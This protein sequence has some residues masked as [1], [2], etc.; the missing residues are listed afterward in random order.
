MSTLLNQQQP[1]VYM[2]AQEKTLGVVGQPSTWQQEQLAKGSFDS[3]LQN[4]QKRDL[5]YHTQL[6]QGQQAVSLP[7]SNTSKQT[8][9]VGVQ[10]FSQG[11]IGEQPVLLGEKTV[12]TQNSGVLMQQQGTFA[13]Q[14]SSFAQQGVIPLKPICIEQE[15]VTFRPQPITIEQPPLMIQPEAITI[16]QP[17]IVIHPEPIVIPQAPLVFQ[18]PAVTLPRQAV[19]YQ[20]DAITLNR[21][22][23]SVQPLIQYDMR[24]C[25]RFGERDFKQHV[26]IRL[27]NEQIM[28]QQMGENWRGGQFVQ[29]STLPAQNVQLQQQGNLQQGNLQQG[30][31]QQGSL[32]QGNFQMGNWGQ[33]GQQQGNLQQQQQQGNWQQQQQQPSSPSSKPVS[34]FSRDRNYNYGVQP[35]TGD[36]FKDSLGVANNGPE[37]PVENLQGSNTNTYSSTGMSGSNANTNTG[38]TY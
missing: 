9:P 30:S 4:L 28:R 37:Q 35:T 5:F 12:T 6:P 38:N 20:P 24:G 25:A 7:S 15:A 19:T 10:G 36:K 23:Y 29:S 13:Q 18:P 17:P 33:Q 3:D 2:P 1:L 8:L 31:L 32:Q 26:H 22:S 21:P 11:G 16:P 14:Q 34:F 27:T